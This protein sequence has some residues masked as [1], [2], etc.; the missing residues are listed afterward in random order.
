MQTIQLEEKHPLALFPT[1]WAMIHNSIGSGQYRNLFVRTPEGDVDVIGDGDLACAFYESSIL[2]LCGLIRGGV[3][4]TVVETVQDLECSGWQKIRELR[5]GC[6]I[7]WGEKP[8]SDGKRHR[9]IGFYI[10]DDC[11]V[12]N[13][14][15]TGCPTRHSIDMCFDVR[16]QPPRLIE[17]LYFHPRLE[18]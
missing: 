16:P 12:S 17:A 13:L 7:V 10:G 14:A 15:H 3:H 2:A 11:A 1:Y 18:E 4:T 5:V 9:H 8:C 6:V